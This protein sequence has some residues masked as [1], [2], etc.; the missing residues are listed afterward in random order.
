[1][2]RLNKKIILLLFVLLTIPGIVRFSYALNNDIRSDEY[3]IKNNI[4]YAVPTTYSYRVE[5]L[6]SK[7]DSDKELK[8]YN[9]NNEELIKGDNVYTGCKLT[10]ENNTYDIVVLGDITGN[11]KIQI[12]DVASLYNYYRG[13]KP[14]SDE[15]VSSGKLTGSDNISI[16]DVAK[17]YNYYKGNKA[18]SY[19]N[20]DM[21]DVDNT[22]EKANMYYLTNATST[23]LGK[24]LATIVDDKLTNKDQV[25]VTREGNVELAINKGD[26]CY[27][28]SALSNEVKVLDGEYCEY[29]INRYASNNGRLHVG[30]SKLLNEYNEEFQ[31]VGVNHATLVGT[32]RTPI[33]AEC[34]SLKTFKTLNTWGVNGIRIFIGRNFWD[35]TSEDYN[36]AMSALQLAIDNAI[37]SDMYVII[38]WNPGGYDYG[39]PKQDEADYFFNDISSKYGNN[40]YIL[41]E[42]WNEAESNYSWEDIK[43]FARHII[44]VIRANAAD[45]IVLVASPEW[46]KR[47]DLVIESPLEI[48]N[49]MYTHHTYSGDVQ[50]N[51]IRYLEEAIEANLP[52]FETEWS[53]VNGG[54]PTGDYIDEAQAI[55]YAKILEKYNISNM[56]FCLDS[57]WWSYNFVDI[58]K[59]FKWD[60]DMP[61]SKL[62]EIAKFLKRIIRHDYTATNFLMTENSSTTI[63]GKYYRSNEYREKIYSVSFKNDKNVPSNAIVSWDLSKI[64]DNSVIGYLVPSTKEDMY[65]LVIGSDGYVN[66]PAN[67]ECLFKGLTNVENYDFSNVKS[68][69][70]FNL[71]QMFAA[72]KKLKTLDLS[73]IVSKK[74]KYLYATFNGDTELETVSF[75]GWNAKVIGH[76]MT[77]TFY[78]CENLKSLDLTGIDV[79]SIT[80][81]TGTFYRNLNLE[82]LNISTWI[83]NKVKKLENTFAGDTKLGYIDLSNFTTFNEGYSITG[84]FGSGNGELRVKTGNEDFKNKLIEMY[85]N[86]IIE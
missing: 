67:S 70:I 53:G 16:G 76:G 5:E 73:N 6:L 65:D 60:E 17:L 77:Y 3:T 59:N 81:F 58:S 49:I 34:H 79:S 50:E 41:Y 45:A 84:I 10:F 47:L 83:P 4:I 9:S 75:D 66:L 24:N 71:S 44:P 37:A 14:L 61:D 1:M 23:Q 85:P 21:I 29:D 32:Q 42:I 13:N 72:N 48:E 22:V 38:N 54:T 40:P 74:V 39:A 86:Y 63:D 51:N 12:G 30:G 80:D 69:L 7:L 19:Y 20:R 46:D 8:V 68:N 33:P 27:R 2:K 43:S 11:G 64:Q 36:V 31:M 25:V 35:P 62:R 56:M 57:G 52:I 18:F 78:N 26:K 28:K 55:T 15:A 82:T